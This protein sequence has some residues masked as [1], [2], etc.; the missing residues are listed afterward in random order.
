MKFKTQLS[1]TL[2]TFQV[3]LGPKQPVVPAPD[4]A[5]REKFS[6]TVL[7]PAGQLCPWAKS[8]SL[9]VFVNEVLLGHSHTHFTDCLLLLLLYCL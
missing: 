9:P 2:A 3:L 6:Q 4:G 8:G 5:H 7:F 1:V